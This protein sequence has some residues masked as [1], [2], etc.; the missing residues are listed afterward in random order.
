M[1]RQSGSPSI[2]FSF[3][4][5]YSLSR[6]F[7][8]RPVSPPL[9]SFVLSDARASS[10]SL[11]LMCR[12][13]LSRYYTFFPAIHLICSASCYA[14]SSRSSIFPSL[15]CGFHTRRI[16]TINFA[17]SPMSLCH[18][19]LYNILSCFSGDVYFCTVVVFG[20]ACVTFFFCPPPSGRS[21]SRCPP[22]VPSHMSPLN[23]P[24]YIIPPSLRYI[25]FCLCVCVCNTSLSLAP[26]WLFGAILLLFLFSSYSRLEYRKE[27]SNNGD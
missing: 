11:S 21:S 10:L 13:A 22:P 12:S 1:V 27:R 4:A 15:C 5:L 3:L 19:F 16:K 18:F 9:P 14:R 2:F 17:S 23:T 26:V 25:I 24:D 7:L 6:N 8:S 20:F